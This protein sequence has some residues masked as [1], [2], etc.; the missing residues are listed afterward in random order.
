MLDYFSLINKYYQPDSI[1]Y[2]IFVVHAVLV[3]NKALQIARKLNL[4]A[5][6]LVFIEEAGMLHDLGVCQV[7]SPK[8][9]C[10]GEL[11]YLEHGV[12][13]AALLRAEGLE[14]HALVAERHIGVGLTKEEIIKRKLPLPARNFLPESLPEQIITFADC[15]F[16]KREATLWHEESPETIKAELVAFGK[17]Q[18]RVFE[19]WERKFLN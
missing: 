6:E 14:K 10:T 12:A 19:H 13:G 3:T 17:E 16:S 2:K 15:F 7:N 9:A 18:L 1:T 5:E 4:S 11:S 8:M